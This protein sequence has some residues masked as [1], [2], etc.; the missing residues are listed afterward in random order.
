MRKL[1]ICS[2][3]AMSLGLAGCGSDDTIEDLQASA[4]TVEPASRVVFDPGDG[5]LS[6]PNDLLILPDDSGF[7]DFTL[8]IPVDDP[9]NFADPQNALNVLDGWSTSHPFTLDFETP[10]GVGLDATT[11]SAGVYLFEAT[12]GLDIRDPDCAAIAIPSA[13]CKVGDQ[14][15]FGVDY[16]LSLSADEETINIVPLSPLK[17]AQ[18]Y[19]L[20]VTTDLKDNNG[21]AVLGSS[22]WESVRQDITE[23][24]LSS[25]SQ[26]A[27]QTLVNSFVNVL[28]PVGFT[29]EE[30]SYVSAFTTQSTTFVMETVKQVHLSYFSAQS[31]FI[32]A[33]DAVGPQ[34]AMEALGLVDA[35]TVA[36]AVALGVSQLP[37]E[38]AALVPLIQATDFSA[39]QTCDG[40]LG[41]ASGALEPVFGLVN[42]FAAGVATGILQ[43]VGPFCAAQRFSGSISL[44]YFSP[45]PSE[46]NPDAPITEFWDAMCD[47]GVILANVSDEILAAT[48][49]GPNAELCASFG[50]AD[51]TI[52]GQNLDAERRLTRFN[53]IPLP[54]GSNPNG[55]ETLDV[56]ITIPNPTV[57]TALGFPITQPEA[58]WPVAILMHGITGNKEQ[59]LSISGTLALAGIATVAIDQPLHGGR[60]FDTDGDGVDDINASANVIDYM[61]LNSLISG[62]DNL[63]QSASDL[64]GLRLGLNAVVDL[65]SSQSV[66]FDT[67]NVHVMGVSLGAIASGSFAAL[68]NTTL[69]GDLAAFDSFFA[70][71]TAS[72]ESP[73]GGIAN[74]LIESPAFGPLIQALLLA[75][76]S[77]DFQA[78]LAANN[79]TTDNPAELIGAAQ[80]FIAGL[81]VEQLAAV[82]SIFSTFVFAAQ[83][84]LDSA[85]PINYG[86]TL[87]GNTP[88]LMLTVVGDGGETNL[89]DQVISVSTSLPLSGQLPY[90]AQVGLQDIVGTV[91][92]TPT[93]SGISKF[94][95]GAHAS[96]I[97]PVPSIQVTTEMQRQIASFMAS[98][99]T[100]I[101]VNDTSVIAN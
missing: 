22:S 89:P 24:P 12:L 49:P 92:G 99:G 45:L 61:N 71:K 81:N 8:N 20:V 25:E 28:E 39:L 85:D 2:S 7:F 9:S 31:T 37:A 86:A 66:K 56:Q 17:A 11:L 96:S 33:G 35:D 42:D 97:N 93:A 55:T 76:G 64:L 63:R 47:S 94:N 84:V 44:P 46:D 75:G 34:N 101:Q 14:L 26:L 48:T 10:E 18:G 43:Q 72:I 79:I 74:F 83:T 29:R 23:A 30:I 98:Q 58:G 50:L 1:I 78:I 53:P 6:A 4:V 91:I 70:V 19:M 15:T 57:S 41:T 3:I 90:A 69:G 36:G 5:V 87:G 73:G 80:A 40:L 16:V 38:A 54:K 51:L 100:V 77:E 88:T 13:G 67:S 27:L 68:A 59:M 62:R 32:L 21:N 60:G 82:Q 65:S 95:S 52:G